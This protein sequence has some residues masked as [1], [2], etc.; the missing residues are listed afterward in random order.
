MSMRCYKGR[1]L[2]LLCLLV[3]MVIVSTVAHSTP[4]PRTPATQIVSIVPNSGPAKGGTRVTIKGQGFAA[5]ATVAFGY[6][7]ASGGYQ[8]ATDV[9]VT[10]E[11]TIVAT[12]PAHE[13]GTVDLIV[14]N[15]GRQSEVMTAAFTYK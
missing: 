3:A 10:N 14:A 15:P 11:T 9:R 12:T 13:P 4:I 2:N 5:G 6:A 7:P 1:R 8:Y